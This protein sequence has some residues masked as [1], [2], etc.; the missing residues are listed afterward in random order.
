MPAHQREAISDE[1]A[2]FLEAGTV[3]VWEDRGDCRAMVSHTPAGLA[4]GRIRAV[5]APPGSRGHGYASA[6]VCYVCRV[7]RDE[8][9]WPYC[10]LFADVD[11][12]PA[13]RL[14][15]RVG[16]KL[17]HTFQEYDFED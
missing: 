3:Y 17:L 2:A 15:Q 9:G 4:P 7:L 5:Y 10:L 8:K 11:S 14:Y 1:A 13:N 16:F 12:A 6:C